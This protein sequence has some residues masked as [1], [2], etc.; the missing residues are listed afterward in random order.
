[1]FPHP[2][3]HPPVKPCCVLVIADGLVRVNFPITRYCR[4]L[5]GIH[6]RGSVPLRRQ[7]LVEIG[8]D[9][10]CLIVASGVGMGLEANILSTRY[11]SRRFPRL[12][13]NPLVVRMA[14]HDEPGADTSTVYCCCSLLV[15]TGA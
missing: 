3:L 14:E 1:M 12:E 7:L 11:L 6:L 13:P 10:L 2:L 9:L 15:C 4:P 5:Y 8:S